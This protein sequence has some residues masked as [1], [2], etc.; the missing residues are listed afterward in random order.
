MDRRAFLKAVAIAAPA[1]AIFW[2]PARQ[3]WREGSL[4]GLT[5]RGDY[6][7]Y[8]SRRDM[9]FLGVWDGAQIRTSGVVRVSYTWRR[10]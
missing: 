1:T 4:I 9:R 2:S 8:D 5:P 3:Q 10:N 7:L 6:A